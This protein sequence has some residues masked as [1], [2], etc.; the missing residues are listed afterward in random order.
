MQREQ[1]AVQQG[2]SR[3]RASAHLDFA[4]RCLNT[5]TT[6]ISDGADPDVA[7]EARLEA[8]RGR[9]REGGDAPGASVER[10]LALLDELTG[11]ELGPRTRR[12]RGNSKRLG[13]RISAS[14]TIRRGCFRPSSRERRGAIARR[15]TPID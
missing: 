12:L 1:A 6:V 7:W 3:Y 15:R 14:L 4:S 13:S 8:I 5:S 2:I 9:L 10:Q 11:F